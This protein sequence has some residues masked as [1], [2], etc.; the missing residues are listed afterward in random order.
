MKVFKSSGRV[1]VLVPL[2]KQLL[3]VSEEFSLRNTLNVLKQHDVYIVGPEKLREFLELYR[4]R[5]GYSFR[6][7]LYQDK[8]F[9]SING[10]NTLL[11][12]KDFY[13]SF[14]DYEYILVVQT[15]ALVF[16]DQLDVWCD[17]NYSYIGAPWFVEFDKPQQSLTF[18]GVGNGGF[19][20]RK[21]NDFI[22]FL[23]APQYVP[24]TMLDWHFKGRQ[25]IYQSLRKSIHK[26]ILSY[27]FSPLM[28]RVQED[29]FWGLLVPRCCSFFTVPTAEEAVSFAFEAA[30][31]YL[32]ELNQHQLPFGCHA[33]EKYDKCFWKKV[34]DDRGINLP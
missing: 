2:Y 33:W 13:K 17:R 23:S 16:S 15:D 9:T 5:T 6:L 27:N 20:L 32:Y 1:A 10:Y 29:I 24:N 3:S 19:S 22:R 12:S 28:P 21:I 14:F 7:A 26:F 31:L 30:P 18:L 4:E 8:F 34:L 11:K 25:S